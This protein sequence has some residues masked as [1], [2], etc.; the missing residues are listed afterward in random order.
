MKIILQR[1]STK[2]GDKI[3]IQLWDHQYFRTN[4]CHT[5]WDWRRSVIEGQII[6]LVS[7]YFQGQLDIAC[8][9]HKV[10]QTGGDLVL[11][12]TSLLLL[13]K[14]SCFNANYRCIY[15]TK[16]ER[17]VSKQGH[18]SLAAIQRPGHWADNCKIVY[19]KVSKNANFEVVVFWK[20]WIPKWK[21]KRIDA[22]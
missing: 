13:Y 15:I 18:S 19:Y 2:S 16:A 7:C 3:I 9:Q 5:L 20:V 11:I 22:E 4:C 17:S 6:L 14:R 8:Y 1:L 12:Q 21:K 10:I